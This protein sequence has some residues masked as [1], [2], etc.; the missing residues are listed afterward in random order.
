VQPAGSADANRSPAQFAGGSKIL[1]R[2]VGDI[3]ILAGGYGFLNLAK[4]ERAWFGA[5]FS[6]QLSRINL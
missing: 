2:I 4:S 3:K 6:E 5:A 1:R